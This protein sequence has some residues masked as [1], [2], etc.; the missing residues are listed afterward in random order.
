MK[1]GECELLFCK[2]CI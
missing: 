2:R 1:A